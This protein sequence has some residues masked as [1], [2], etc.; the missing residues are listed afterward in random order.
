MK[1]PK[2]NNIEF[3]TSFAKLIRSYAG[4]ANPDISLAISSANLIV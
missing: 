2:P 3:L 1:F 4:F